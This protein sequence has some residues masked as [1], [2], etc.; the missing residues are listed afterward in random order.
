MKQKICDTTSS[1]LS[2]TCCQSV[3]TVGCNYKH[4]KGGIAQVMHTYSKDVY[5]VF[6]CV[7]NSGGNSFLQKLMRAIVA[8][9]HTIVL[10]IIDRRIKILHIHTASYNSF[11]RSA[12]WV[13][14]GKFFHKKIVLHIHG[15]GFKEYYLTN[16]KWI[17]SVLDRSDC[18]IALSDSW[19][20]YFQ[21]ELGC[22]Q[23]SIV[24]NV[25]PNPIFKAIKQSDDRMHLLFLG[26]IDEEKG[27]FDLLEMIAEHK[28]DLAERILL[29][30]GGLGKVDQLRET[31]ARLQ[32][33]SC[34][35][36]EGFVAG[37]QKL[38]L[39][40]LSDVFILP[41]YIEGL[42]IA[43]LEAMSYGMPVLSTPVGGIPEVVEHG[44][45]GYLF[46][47]GNKDQMFRSISELLQHPEQV[48][49]MG[50]ISKKLATHDLPKQTKD[51][52]EAIYQQLLA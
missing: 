30:I 49:A 41:S 14:L 25:I 28:D 47:P 50:T 24:E 46:E 44:Q 32:L 45:N 18:L 35:S 6:R 11:K 8:T 26:L 40:N 10:L 52:L 9:F 36:Y 7:V 42:P 51:K 21:G 13:S 22:K 12:Y 4:P 20:Q 2:E 29:H 39:L 48:E 15:G 33:A 34:V 31:I 1:K 19:K 23:V 43:I 38:N 16:P 17:Q 37:E 27:I 3:L 5:S